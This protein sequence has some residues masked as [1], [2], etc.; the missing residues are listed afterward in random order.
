MPEGKDK[1]ERLRRYLSLKTEPVCFKRLDDRS[2]LDKIEGVVLV[3][4]THTFCQL[5]FMVRTMGVTLGITPDSKVLDRCKR[6]HA[7]RPNTPEEMEKETLMLSRTW[8]GSVEDALA[9]QKDYPLM[10]TGEAVLLSPLFRTSWEPDVISIFGNPAQIMMILCGLQKVKYEKFDF[11][12]IGEG[13]CTDS[14]ARC[15]VTGKPSL[16]I[17]CYGERALGQ[18][19]DD[20]I[21]LALPPRELDRALEGLRQLR[22]VGFSYPVVY[23]G[24]LANPLKALSRFY[25]SK[26][27]N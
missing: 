22:K 3:E 23:I 9:Q 12:F 10:P 21:I 11:S 25:P 5:P 27:G 17:P 2:M 8:F 14:I 4:D 19:A 26:V 16:S 15:Y 1:S 13:A 7:L 20:E 18:V 6:L 24:S